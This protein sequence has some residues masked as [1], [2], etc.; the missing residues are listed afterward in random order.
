MSNRIDR[1]LSR[2]TEQQKTALI[3]FLTAG[4]PDVETAISL[5]K[6]IIEAGADVLELGVPFSDPLAD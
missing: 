3:P 5:A 6:A 4:F 2:L 1:T